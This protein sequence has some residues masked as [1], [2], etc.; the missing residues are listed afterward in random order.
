MT[1]LLALLAHI[2]WLLVF[3]NTYGSFQWFAFCACTHH[4][5]FAPSAFCKKMRLDEFEGK[6]VWPQSNFLKVSAVITFVKFAYIWWTNGVKTIVII[7]HFTCKCNGRVLGKSQSSTDFYQM[8][9][10]R[11]GKSYSD[12][13]LL[14][15]RLDNVIKR[16]IANVL[17]TELKRDLYCM[18]GPLQYDNINR[19]AAYII[20][21]NNLREKISSPTV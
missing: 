19:S 5:H 16:K 2:W 14:Q 9:W 21:T 13:N 18:Q 8:H 17:I 6:R 12:T 4:M 20:I 3:Q 1:K 15:T 11:L 10:S 7:I